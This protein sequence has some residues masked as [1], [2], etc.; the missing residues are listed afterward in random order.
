MRRT[1]RIALALCAALLAAL[2]ACGCLAEPTFDCRFADAD[3]GR[4]LLLDNEAY[5]RGLTQND[6]DFRMQKTGATLEEWKTFA[7]AQVLDF[8][9]AERDYIAGQLAELAS[10]CAGKG[11]ALPDP[12]PLTFVKTTMAEECGAAGYTHGTQSYL[13]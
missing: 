12:G 5:L 1:R 8:T 10:L 3:E 11:Y 9:D 7:A 4:A 6:L 13:G 2:C